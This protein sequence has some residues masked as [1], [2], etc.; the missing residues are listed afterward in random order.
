MIYYLDVALNISFFYNPLTASLVG[1]N[2]E[3]FIL[4]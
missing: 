1:H 3:S 4:F 2:I